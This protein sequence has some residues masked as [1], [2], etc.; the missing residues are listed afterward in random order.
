MRPRPLTHTH[1]PNRY[2]TNLCIFL[3]VLMT[4]ANEDDLSQTGVV[5]DPTV[6]AASAADNGISENRLTDDQQLYTGTDPGASESGKTEEKVITV[7]KKVT[8]RFEMN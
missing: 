5:T 8:K 1:T 7:I 2:Q 3:L 6:P 4:H